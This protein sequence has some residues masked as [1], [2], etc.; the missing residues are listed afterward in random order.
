MR[1]PHRFTVIGLSLILLR[2]PN[3]H[4]PICYWSVGNRLRRFDV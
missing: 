2:V 3:I 4:I 1:V